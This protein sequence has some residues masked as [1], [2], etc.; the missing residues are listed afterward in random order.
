MPIPIRGIVTPLLTPLRPS[1]APDEEALERL[2]NHVIRGGVSGIFLL[3]TT[4]EG[5]ALSTRVQ[6]DVIRL[7]A[8]H[9]EGRV[10]LLAGIAD[11]S[12]DEA[13]ALARFAAAAGL[14]AVVTTGPLYFAVS[15]A[16]LADYVAKLAR[17]SP[18]PVFLYNIPGCSHVR[19]PVDVVARCAEMANVLGFKDSSGEIHYLHKV[20]TA[21]AGRPDFSLLIGP[22]ELMGEAVLFGAHGGVNGGSNLF[23]EL[24]VAMYEAAVRADTV[25]MGRLQ[26]KILAL[27]EA[28]YEPTYLPGIKCAAAALGLCDE[29]F[30]APYTPVGEPRRRAIAGFLESCTI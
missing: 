12:F 23:P 1:G 27:S 30:A 22:E 17:E 25:E 4:G 8:K 3:G 24:Y 18:I 16:D 7:A 28:V 26:S 11:T 10:P 15:P 6:Q 14:D 5:P 20:R 13:V 9:T 19:F 2:I 29:V 21:L